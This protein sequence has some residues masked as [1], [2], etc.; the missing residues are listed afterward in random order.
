MRLALTRS[1]PPRAFMACII[2]VLIPPPSCRWV[3]LSA[4][5]MSPLGRR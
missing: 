4:T 1:E 2:A 5:S 3:E